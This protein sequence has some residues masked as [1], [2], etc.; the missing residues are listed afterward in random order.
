MKAVYLAIAVLVV[1][2]LVGC[3]GG[4]SEP[5]VDPI[6]PPTVD[7]RVE[8]PVP[9]TYEGYEQA[10]LLVGTQTWKIYSNIG[11]AVPVP[12]EQNAIELHGPLY[13]DGYTEWTLTALSS[14]RTDVRIMVNNEVVKTIFVVTERVDPSKL[15]INVEGAT[16]VSD[17][18]M[19]MGGQ[20][21]LGESRDLKISWSYNGSPQFQNI[22]VLWEVPEGLTLEENPDSKNV[23]VISTAYGSQQL[24]GNVAGKSFFVMY[25]VTMELTE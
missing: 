17:T 6:H 12:V 5:T 22:P 8:T 7:V 18:A 19:Y 15:T 14:W 4:S 11:V 25:G 24:V 16:R 21:L 9:Y 10:A 3:G 13:A 23:R 1:A 2:G 20:M